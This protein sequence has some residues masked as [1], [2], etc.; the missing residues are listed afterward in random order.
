MSKYTKKAR[1]FTLIELLVVIAIISLLVSILLP[2]LNKAR[3]LARTVVCLTNYRNIGTASSMYTSDFDGRYATS[4]YSNGN[5]YSNGLETW[6][7]LTFSYFGNNTDGLHVNPRG[8]QVLDFAI[9]NCPSALKNKASHEV[10]AFGCSANMYIC[11]INLLDYGFSSPGMSSSSA[12]PDMITHA[13][14]SIGTNRPLGVAMAY[15]SDS[16]HCDSGTLWSGMTMTMMNHLDSTN[17]LWVDG[18]ASNE[19]DIIEMK[20]I[21]PMSNQ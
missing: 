21:M 6:Q 18:H 3:E 11:G 13:E 15:P 4:I 17:V 8:S 7:S 9:F 12:N 2:S 20:S 16:V 19:K 1:A 10:A 14:T 5:D